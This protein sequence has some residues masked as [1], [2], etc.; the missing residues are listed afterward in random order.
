VPA[1]GL[2]ISSVFVAV[3]MIMNYTEGLVETFSFFILL[4]T[5]LVLIPYLFSVTS[6]GI[7]LL[8]DK[9]QTGLPIKLTIT[10]IAFLFSIWALIGAGEKT[11]YYGFIILM[12]GIPMYVYI[13]AT[14][15]DQ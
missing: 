10:I 14:R 15:K 11:V 4:S 6:Y 1:F 9:I 12:L 8:E 7:L 5:T 3:M 13:K 2:V